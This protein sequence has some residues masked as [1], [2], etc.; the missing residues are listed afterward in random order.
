MQI[1]VRLPATEYQVLIPNKLIVLTI[2]ESF[3]IEIISKR[4]H[5][6]APFVLVWLSI[7]HIQIKNFPPQV[8][9][10]EV[11]PLNGGNNF[12][13]LLSEGVGDIGLLI[14]ADVLKALE[15]IQV[16]FV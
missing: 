16:S 2:F 11:K 14:I 3:L 12:A 15:N 7:C 13:Q 6:E 4:K 5:N 8:L 1:L 9:I 10:Q